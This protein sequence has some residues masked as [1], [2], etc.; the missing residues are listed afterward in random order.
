MAT[1]HLAPAGMVS[2]AGRD[3][4]V[5]QTSRLG[6]VDVAK[7]IGIVLVVHGHAVDG[8]MSAG[9]L[10]KSGLAAFSFFAVYCFHMPLFF[11]LSGLFVPRQIERDRRRFA[12]RQ[13]GTIVWPYL[14]WSVVQVTILYLASTYTNRPREE[15]GY[16]EILWAPP[17]Q[18]WFLYVLFLFHMVAAALVRRDTAVPMLVTGIFAFVAFHV[19]W[20]RAT[21]PHFFTEL[22]I[23][24]AAGIAFAGQITALPGWFVRHRVW[25]IAACAAI[26]PYIWFG[27]SRGLGYADLAMVPATLVGI[28]AVLTVA[29]ALSGRVA[30]LFRF[31]GERAMAIYVLHVLFVAGT[32][33]VLAKLLGVENGAVLWPILLAVG[34][35]GPVVTFELLARA[36]WNQR[37]GLGARPRAT[38][39][40]N[41]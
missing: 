23:F 16:A 38:K 18:F 34:V 5:R 26:L 1:T 21:V 32:R 11:L 10:S 8:L 15:L 40:A 9:L 13:V 7:G 17:S 22:L 19:L 30:A 2:P 41:A 35:A 28:C 20:P 37:L 3:E 25:V 31:L 33:I 24:Y 39:V 27:F 14:L 4:P 12:W 29:T 36:G 6:W